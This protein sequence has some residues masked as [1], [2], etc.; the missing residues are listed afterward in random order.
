MEGSQ[1]F[2][3]E[4]PLQLLLN[5]EQMMMSNQ[6]G[7]AGCSRCGEKVSAPC[8][9][10]VV[11]GFY[12]HKKCAEAPSEIYHPFHRDH[13]L[14]LQ[15]IPSYYTGCVCSFCGETCKML[16]Y[17]CTC[18]LDF[19]IKCALFTYDIAEKNLK[20]L[21]HVALEDPL[22][23]TKN[24]LEHPT[25]CFACW[26][27][28]AN[29]TYFS[30]D[31]GFNLHKKCVDL[32]LKINDIGHKHPLSLQFNS[33]QLS[34]DVCGETRQSGFVYC[35]P[36]CNSAIHIECVP[37]PI[38]EVKCRQHAFT[39]F[40]RRAP[41]ICDACGIQADYVAYICCSCNIILH[42]KCISLP[43]VIKSKWHDHRIFHTYF[44]LREDF[45]RWDCL[46]C[47]DEVNVSHGSYSC[48]DC[49]FIFHVKCVTEIE[50]SYFIVSLENE[51]EKSSDSLAILQDIKYVDPITVIE[52]NDA[53]K[54]TKIKHFMH[55]HNLVSRDEIADRY[56]KCCDGCRLPISASFYYCSLCD[57][58]LHKACAELPKMKHVWYHRCQKPLILNSYKFLECP[59]CGYLSNGFGYRCNECV[60]DI[61]FRCVIALSPGAS[62]C[63]G[64]DHPLFYYKGYRGQCS[65]CGNDV[66]GALRCKDCN[67]GLCHICFSLPTTAQ[68]KCDKHVLA[69]T[70]H[71]SNNYS[72]SH[73]CDICEE[74][75]DPNHWFYHCAICDN[76]AHIDCVLGRYP[77]IKLGHHLIR[78]SESVIYNKGNHPHF[79]AFVKKMYYYPECVK[80]GEP[81][82]DLALECI[83]S[84]CNYTVH[85]E[86]R[87]W[88]TTAFLS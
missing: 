41:F 19:H 16:V 70:Y 36:P 37:P 2:G 11:C 62:T 35:C 76:S 25:M 40:R 42:E 56:D 26:E 30:A 38:V 12:L 55:V 18:E 71:E 84:G 73:Y 33:K 5:E 72:E 34:C 88:S 17:R 82:Q 68:H 65:A 52:R 27:P 1:N 50:G 3:H 14:V 64:H 31:C 74:A 9:S 13:P 63:P 86:C 75:R 24:K 6:S 66:R 22:I 87:E 59:I 80:C 39:L 48:S 83:V 77:Y 29:Y 53:G 7:V 23:S 85:W 4:H 46:I 21:E 51:D 43:R 79:L 54:A 44:L 60:R 15:Q 8:F 45:K 57:F 78:L 81:C 61:C 58:F 69:L 49:N 28:L 10:C 20:E 67:F 32:P 47:H